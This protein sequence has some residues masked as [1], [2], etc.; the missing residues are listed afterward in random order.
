MRSI[1]FGVLA[2]AFAVGIVGCGG[3][4]GGSP[5]GSGSNPG[6]GQPTPA[7]NLTV[8]VTSAAINASIAQGDP[9]SATVSGTWSAT[10]LGSGAVYLQVSDSANTF[11]LPAI[12]VAPANGAFSFGLPA[13]ATLATGERTGTITVKACK[14]ATCSNA[15]AGTSGS[16]G[17]QITINRV[18][19]WETFQANAAHNGF[20][21]ITLDP[22]KFAKAWEWKAPSIPD[23]S[24]V[25]VGMLVTGGDSVYSLVTR[26]AANGL[27]DS[28]VALAEATGALRWEARLGPVTGSGVGGNNPAY[29]AGRLYVGVAGAAEY[30][31]LA[32][33]TAN[34]SSTFQA[35]PGFTPRSGL[36]PTPYDGGVYALDR[37][38]GAG[39]QPNRLFW[40]G[41]N[42]G[43]PVWSQYINQPEQGNPFFT[44]AVDAQHLYYHDACCLKM[45]DRRT[46]SLIASV[47]N[48]NADAGNTSSRAHPVAIGSRGN[49]LAL[50]YTPAP[51]KRVLS[52]FNIAS[53]VREWTT[54]LD[55]DGYIASANGVAYVRRIQDGQP[56]LYAIDEANGQVLW[57][58]TP[59]AGDAQTSLTG[60]IVA[61]RNLVFFSTAN[62]T[63][64]TGKTW[65][66][67]IAS[68]QAV[69]SYPAP[70]NVV[71]S[72][73]RMIYITP[74]G[75]GF[76]EDSVVAFRTR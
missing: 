71:I 21:P 24:F 52:S 38:R 12:Q 69:W 61:T 37:V 14:D 6:G 31:L 25:Y 5:S 42:G 2:C 35:N 15:H 13:A 39:S 47:L 7:A 57:T 9:Y 22:G 1:G 53:R 40:M 64:G 62:T 8:N 17:Y 34:G 10:N 28:Y 18:P 67:D 30:S 56:L 70:G 74:M 48:T 68:R 26:E 33:D 3:G 19:D 60:N 73:N 36:A 27:A 43:A 46:G 29:S 66:I 76:D 59:P 72:S 41:S 50:A 44:P 45:L 63:T 23:T 49:V 4:G 16:I 54:A 51:A 55:F 20:V 75:D 11:T 65:A 32:L 58:W